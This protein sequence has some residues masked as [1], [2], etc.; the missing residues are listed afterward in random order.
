[1]PRPL[2]IEYAG[3][4]YHVFF[5]RLMG[6]WLCSTDWTQAELSRRAKVELARLLCYDIPMSCHWIFERLRI[7]RSSNVAELTAPC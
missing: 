7:G 2:R 1:M 3:A 4:I 6:E 5:G